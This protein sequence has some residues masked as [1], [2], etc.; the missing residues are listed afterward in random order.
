MQTRSAGK[1]I[2]IKT[3]DDAAPVLSAAEAFLNR[4]PVEH[5][6]VLTLLNERAHHPE[7]GRYWTVLVN[8]QVVGLALQSPPTIPAV[9]TEVPL[10]CIEKLAETIAAD[11]PDLP[12]IFGEAGIAARFT[13]CWAEKLKIPVAP[14]EAVRLYQLALLHPPPGAPGSVR[15][16]TD[17]DLELILSWLEGFRRDTAA[18]TAAP[19]A[20]RRRIQAGLVSIWEDGKPVSMASTTTPL[21]RTVRVG[22]VYT[23]PEHRGRG[24]AASCVAAVSQAAL[25]SG[26]SQCVLFTQ[27]SNPQSNAIYRRLGYE[28]IIELLRYRFGQERGSS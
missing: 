19:D 27:L 1:Q 26:A 20:M 6:L 16:A 12:G 4:T 15:T 28:P 22:L 21:A 3:S 23:P 10:E 9:V 2:E 18:V 17:A 7:P 24:Y 13:G 8:D 11:R 25:D 14:V 5:N